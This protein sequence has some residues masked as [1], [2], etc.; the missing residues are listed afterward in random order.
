M[1][2]LSKKTFKLS[3]AGAA[4]VSRILALERPKFFLSKYF[5]KSPR[6]GIFTRLKSNGSGILDTIPILNFVQILGTAI[7]TVGCV[8]FRL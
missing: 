1:P 2:N 6:K 5:K 7:K 8:C 3:E 4:P